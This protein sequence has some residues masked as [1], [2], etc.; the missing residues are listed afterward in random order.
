MLLT[1]ENTPDVSQKRLDS[2]NSLSDEQLRLEVEKGRASKFGETMLPVLRAALTLR[3][4]AHIQAA[5]EE[6]LDIGRKAN[7]IAKEA[8]TEA[9]A[10]NQKSDSARLWSAIRN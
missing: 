9:K 7:R 2:V 3:E 5:R 1:P 8:L 6:E 10:A 4:E